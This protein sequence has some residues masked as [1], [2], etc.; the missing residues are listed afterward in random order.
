[1]CEARRYSTYQ[2]GYLRMF[3]I[4][5]IAHRHIYFAFSETGRPIAFWIW[6][7]LAPDIMQLI[8]SDGKIFLHES[9]W[10][11]GNNLLILDFCAPHG[12]VKDIISYMRRS[13]YPKHEQAYSLRRG[14]DGT[15]RKISVWKRSFLNPQPSENLFYHLPNYSFASSKGEWLRKKASSL[16]FV[17]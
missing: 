1:M 6:A 16:K 3:L 14:K 8:I 10:N 2:I 17:E 5:A 9:E 13:M 15:I 11:E 4:P 12:H 7:T